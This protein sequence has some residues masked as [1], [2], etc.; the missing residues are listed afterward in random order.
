MKKT[1]Y[2][3]SSEEAKAVATVR[4]DYFE[5]FTPK[6]IEWGNISPESVIV[7]IPCGTGDLVRLM[8]ERSLCEFAYLID[9][10]PTMVDAAREAVP[11]RASYT[12]A[13]AGQISAVVAQQVD[14][15]V[16]LNGLHIYIDEKDAFLNGCYKI[17]K[18]G[19]RLIFDVST[20]GLNHDSRRYL[21]RHDA[22]M[23][24]KASL[25]GS[26]AI[27]PP[28]ADQQMIDSYAEMAKTAGFDLV[29]MHYIEKVIDIA[30]F[31]DSTVNIP[32]RL[33]SRFPQLDDAARVK[34][35]TETSD[36]AQQ[37]TGLSTVKHTRVFYVL[38]KPYANNRG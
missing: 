6:V 18:P 22:L 27:L 32:G 30:K 1:S 26:E 2:I 3:T 5:T 25:L 10:N 33:R 4:K 7:D 38:E 24:E 29:D 36:Q 11:E 37:E 28:Y 8:R 13:D 16:C 21:D 15:V 31:N 12:V 35:F 9:I 19:G 17:L 34:L 23:R 14:A 20:M